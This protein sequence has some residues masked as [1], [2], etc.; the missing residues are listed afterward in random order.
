MSRSK[1]KG[2]FIHYKF[3]KKKKLF[4][5]ISKIWL[6]NSIILSSFINQKFLI[7]N[8]KVFKTFVVTREKIGYKFGEFCTTRAKYF[9]KNKLKIINKKQS[10][11]KKK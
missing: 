2:P 3:L 11:D 1:W 7:H 9:H 6:R 8:G 4:N 5:K 10:K